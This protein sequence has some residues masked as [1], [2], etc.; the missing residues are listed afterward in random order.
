M[1]VRHID[2]TQ[3]S[4]VHINKI[5]KEN[6][7]SQ[8]LHLFSPSFPHILLIEENLL[9]ATLFSQMSTTLA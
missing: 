4:L 1:I 9:F 3:Y 2:I 6:I 7:S 8:I 5:L